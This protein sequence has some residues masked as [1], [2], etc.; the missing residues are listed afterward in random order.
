MDIEEV[1]DDLQ[2]LI[3]GDCTDSKMDYVEQIEFAI[4][5]LERH[6]PRKP[7]DVCTPVVTWGLCPVCQGK[8]NML[9]RRPNRVFKDTNFCP[10][11]GQALD[12]SDYDE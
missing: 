8:L 6:I 10:D 5:A 2:Y 11:C 7:T 9:G 3:S 1:I 12:W 4:K